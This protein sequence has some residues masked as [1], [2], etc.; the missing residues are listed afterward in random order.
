[1]I[2]SQPTAKRLWLMGDGTIG[3]AFR[4][5]SAPNSPLH[6]RG[7]E[8]TALYLVEVHDDKVTRTNDA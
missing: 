4:R 6:P 1:M 7:F 8:I 3:G 2:A 5:R